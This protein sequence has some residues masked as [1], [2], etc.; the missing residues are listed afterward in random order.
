M[1]M[2]TFQSMGTTLIISEDRI[3]LEHNR[4]IGNLRKTIEIAFT[5]LE[6]IEERKPTL[7]SG[8]VYFRRNHDP[9]ID[10]K[11]AMIHEQA[12]IIRSKKKYKEYEKVSELIKQRIVENAQQTGTPDDRIDSLVKQLTSNPHESLR[13]EAH[14]GHLI[15]SA[16]TVSIHHKTLHRGGNGQR[17]FSISSINSI[18]LSKSG[19]KAGRIRFF[20]ESTN[21]REKYKAYLASEN[22]L[23]ITGIDDYHRMYEAKLLIERLRVYHA[24]KH[25]PSVIPLTPHSTADELREFKA[26]LDEGIITEEEFEQKKAQL[27]R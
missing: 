18:H 25:D 13:Y 11:E 8:Y 9:S 17:E 7:F 22:E 20:T 1:T 26:L 12:M 5:E 27:L 14:Q 16:H 6:K 23:L 2:A 21:S 10:D 19:L 3:T 24:D 4:K 15:I